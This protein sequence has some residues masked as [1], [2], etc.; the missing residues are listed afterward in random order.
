FTTFAGR[1]N[2]T[3]CARMKRFVI[4]LLLVASVLTACH[5]PRREA[6]RM[7]RRAEQLFDTLP[8]ST[9][10][11]IDSVLRMPV[12]FNEKRRMD[13]ALLQ[14]EALFGD[15][16]QE[17]PP[18]M[19]DDFFDDRPFL[20]ASPE[21]ERAGAYYARKEQYDKAAHAAL[22][23]GFIQQHYSEKQAA[24]QSFKDAEH[25]G[26]EA[27]DSLTVARAQYWIGKLLFFDG[28]NQEA[29]FQLCKAEKHFCNRDIERSFVQNKIAVCHLLLG[30]Y[31]NAEACLKQS[32]ILSE[33]CHVGIVKRKALN[34]YAVLCQILGKYD[35]AIACLRQIETEP[36]L[37]DS[38]LL[39]L[40]INF[41]DVFTEMNCPDSAVSYY[42]QVETLLPEADIT[43]ETKVSAYNSLFLFAES[44]HND[45]SA[46]VYLK[47]CDKWL[48]EVRD[49]RE[50][51][52]VYG[53]QKKYDYDALQNTMNQKVIRRQRIIIILSVIAIVVLLALVS[54][55]VRL[56]RIRRQEKEIKASLFRFMQQNEELTKQ[57]E[58]IKQAHQ[59]LEQKHQESEEARQSLASQVQEYK[60]AYEKSD[61]KLSKAILK[62]HQI[63][64]KMAVFLANESDSVLFSTLKYSVLG[65]DEYWEA[66]L[67]TFDKQFPGMRRKLAL[68]HPDLTEQ[69]QKVL[70]LSYVDASREDTAVLLDT[71]VFMVDKLR[72]SV[73]KKMGENIPKASK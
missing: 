62:Q 63:M 55:Q 54:S 31:E 21:L 8:D 1:N 38:E 39:L 60:T 27:N 25:Y 50:Q 3:I 12:Y 52:N 64:Q 34:N 2:H 14:G 7:V 41:G 72:T 51:N 59:E 15:R 10:S 49:K 18:V 37:D 35:Q 4:I 16:G 6:R 20:T 68:Q 70:L 36:Y 5:S 66:M 33:K 58:N 40:Y 73:K 26:E 22:Y 24:M 19:D 61:K 28:M 23:S 67:K 48:N 45:S 44:Q 65:G 42:K 53:I 57:S 69:E 9:A 17:I 13:M 71:S 29:L 43:M 30:D 11:L 46:L 56:A 32:L 47:C